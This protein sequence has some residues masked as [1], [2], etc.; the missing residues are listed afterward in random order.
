MSNEVIEAQ[1][2]CPDHRNYYE[3]ATGCDTCNYENDLLNE[4]EN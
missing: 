1:G 4:R 3:V 2:W